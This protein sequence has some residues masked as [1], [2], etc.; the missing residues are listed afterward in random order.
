M[1]A[2]AVYMSLLGPQGFRELGETIIKRSHYAARRLADIPGVGVRFGEAFFK[3]FVV[4]FTETGKTVARVDAALRERGI[5]GG[6]DLSRDFPGLGQSAL[7]C[8]TELHTKD[9][10]DGLA[11]AV[12]EIVG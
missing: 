2:S 5:F 6:L 7:Y 8:V 9:D 10:L 4:D 12:R 1:V 3:E 11:A